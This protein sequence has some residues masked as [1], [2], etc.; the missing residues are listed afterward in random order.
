ML[1]R[2]RKGQMMNR[3]FTGMAVVMLMQLPGPAEASNQYFMPG[4]AFFHTV[5]TEDV[6]DRVDDQENPVFE[7]DRPEFLPQ[8]LCGNI[9]FQK[10][11]YT[12]MSPAMKGNLRS[13]YDQLRESHP[14]RVEIRR[15][16]VTRK[17]DE[18]DIEV[19]TGKKLHIEINGFSVLFYNADFDMKKHRLALKYNE[20]WAD[21]FAAWGHKRNHAIL[22]TFVPTKQAIPIDWRDGPAVRPLVAKL[23]ARNSGGP[24]EVDKRVMAIII[25]GNDFERVFNAQESIPF[26]R[27]NMVLFA[28]S[29]EGIKKLYGNRGHWSDKPAVMP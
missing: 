16:M 14:K 21:E 5:L 22:E 8:M 6:L 2:K 27:R 11:Q 12:K 4:D 1:D 25:P 17:T 20:R 10:L 29:A 7:Y 28:V 9:G 19:P 15:E 3:M 24:I 23:P 26:L 13:A 18:G